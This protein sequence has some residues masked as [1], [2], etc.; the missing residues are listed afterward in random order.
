M[1]LHLQD[2]HIHKDQVLVLDQV[3]TEDQHHLVIEDQVGIEDQLN[4]V[5]EDQHRVEIE[6]LLEIEDQ[7]EEDTGS[8]NKHL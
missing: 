5:I 6:N 2:R 7:Q 3:V 1:T 8:Y 4:L